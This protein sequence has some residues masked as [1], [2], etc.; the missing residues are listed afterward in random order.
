V[1]K[2]IE[3]PKLDDATV[4]DTRMLTRL[5]AYAMGAADTTTGADAPRREEKGQGRKEKK[6]AEGNAEV[7]PD[8]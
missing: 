5:R 4:T 6:A 2:V 8:L 1:A 3:T 7:P